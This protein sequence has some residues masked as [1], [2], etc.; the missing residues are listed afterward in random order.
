MFC[1]LC[2]SEYRDGFT[3]CSDCHVRLVDSREVAQSSSER[4][5]KGDRQHLFDRILAALDAQEIP[6]RFKETVNAA[7]RILGISLTSSKSTFEF[8]V[9]V[10]RSDL[11]R[12]RA[13]I[14]NL[15]GEV[16]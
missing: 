3:E 12:A 5:W 8:E 10:F 15:A 6:F 16:S 1:P 11:E 9:W 14:A 13:A 2:Q 7:P 4:L